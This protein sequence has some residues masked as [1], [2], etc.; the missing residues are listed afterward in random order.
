MI[1]SL[2]ILS[3]K[4]KPETLK[5]TKS[6]VKTLMKKEYENVEVTLILITEDCIRTSTTLDDAVTNDN[7]FD[8]S[9]FNN[10]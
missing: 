7:F 8:D 6:G 5:T 9:F 2:M 1:T 3:L 10:Y 4:D